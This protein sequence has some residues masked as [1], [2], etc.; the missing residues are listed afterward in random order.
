MKRI[1]VGGDVFYTMTL[2]E[3]LKVN[4]T[5]L[6]AGNFFTLVGIGIWVWVFS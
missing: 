2:P 6:L 5:F 4:I 1:E 3:L